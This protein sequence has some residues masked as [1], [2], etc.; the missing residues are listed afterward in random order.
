M[1]L[2]IP[3][4]VLALFLIGLPIRIGVKGCFDAET[5]E[6]RFS[7]YLCGVP[8]IRIKTLL[9]RRGLAESDLFVYRKQRKTKLKLSMKKNDLSDLADLAKNPKL[10]LI[11]NINVEE[12]FLRI[13]YG[14]GDA[15]RTV[16]AVQGV[17]TLFYAAMSVVK[18]K[19]KV[20][21]LEEFVPDFD[22]K[23]ILA[24]FHGILSISVADIIYGFFIGIKKKARI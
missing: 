13:R 19:Q 17:R 2:L 6:G 12:V 24:D 11:G 14:G 22:K 8:I 15:I 16:L 5:G 23:T 1:Y 4:A 21:V 18:A 9:E 7:F 10:A 3:A 20:N